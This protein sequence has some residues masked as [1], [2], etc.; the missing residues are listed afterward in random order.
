MG[1]YEQADTVDARGLRLA[2]VVARFNAARHRPLLE[3]GAL[4]TLAEHGIVGAD[5]PVCRVPGAFELPLVAQAARGVG[6]RATR[7]SASVP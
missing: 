2:I 1:T 7:S 4:E 6:P 5:A 3:A